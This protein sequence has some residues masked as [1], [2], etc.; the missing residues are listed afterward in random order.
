MKL[1]KV[2]DSEGFKTY[3]KDKVERV[4]YR[5]KTYICSRYINYKGTNVLDLRKQKIV[6]SMM[7][8]GADLAEISMAIGVS[9]RTISAFLAMQFKEQNCKAG[10]ANSKQANY[11][12]K[13][14]KVINFSDNSIAVYTS[15][16][17]ASKEIGCSG[18]N[19]SNYCRS[20][21]VYCHKATGKEY[22]MAFIENEEV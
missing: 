15:V 21:K 11:K 20:G 2:I 18:S 4:S 22:K 19:I 17:S 13:R 3:C 6:N 7:R 8:E 12:R 1:I 14:V 5:G 10:Q 16:T 9:E